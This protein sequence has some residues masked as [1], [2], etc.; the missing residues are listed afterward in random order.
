MIKL[1]SEIFKKKEKVTIGESNM[2]EYKG[3]PMKLPYIVIFI[4]MGGKAVVNVNFKNYLLKSN[5]ILVLSHDSIAAFMRTSND[6]TV[7]YCMLDKDFASEI[8]YNLPN[9]LFAFLWESPICIPEKTELPL[10]EMW[11][12]QLRHIKQECSMHQYIMLRNHLQNFFL[13]ITEKIS[14]E[15]SIF[16]KEY[17]RKEILCWKFWDMIGKHCTQHR[18]VTFYAKELCITPFYLSQITKSQFGDSP[19]ELINR[20]VILEI[21]SLLSS[22]DLSIKEI[23]EQLHFEDTSYMCR[24]FKRQIGMSLSEYRK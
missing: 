10:L 3:Y 13:K 20:Q 6:F 2:E 9:H 22:T 18:D 17:S 23:A 16:Q 4:C 15:N 7:F 24:Y 8:A 11:L 1:A 19:K 14:M 5:D 12:E 21:K